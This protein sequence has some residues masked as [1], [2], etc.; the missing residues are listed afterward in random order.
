MMHLVTLFGLVDRK[1]RDIGPLIQSVVVAFD[2]KGSASCVV[3][4]VVP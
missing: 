2:L 4:N 3:Q 1:V